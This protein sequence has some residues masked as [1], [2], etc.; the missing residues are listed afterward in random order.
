MHG[1]FHLGQVLYTGGDFHIIDFEG[2]P[3]RT[4]GE[5]RF[6]RSPLRDV[7]GMLRSFHYASETAWR[8]GRRRAQDVPVLEPWARAWVDWV[9]TCYVRAW[10]E[11]CADARFLPADADSRSVMLDFYAIEKCVYELGYELN[12]RIDWLDLPIAGLLAM[13]ENDPAPAR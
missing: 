1:D 10:F 4:I 3:G 2:E 6:R 8:R 5:R 11:H 12:N 7:A 9:S 13:A